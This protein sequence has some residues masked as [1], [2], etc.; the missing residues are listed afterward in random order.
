MNRLVSEQGVAITL[1]ACLIATA[2]WGSE[3]TD[4]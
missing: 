1:L 2:V 3:R 4:T